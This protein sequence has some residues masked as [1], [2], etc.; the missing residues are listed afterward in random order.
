M[1]AYRY[2]NNEGFTVLAACSKNWNGKLICHS[3]RDVQIE[4]D[5]SAYGWGA[6]PDTHRATGA[7][8]YYTSRQSSNFRELT[9]VWI[10]LKSFAPI[11]KNK[12]LQKVSNS[13]TTVSYI[14]TFMCLY[15]TL[16]WA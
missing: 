1:L 11:I 2:R 15:M 5:D 4:T 16:L 14:N 13:L 8:D 3:A 10:A 6:Q 7:W 12:F 9:A